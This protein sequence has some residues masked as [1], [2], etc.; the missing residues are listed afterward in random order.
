MRSNIHDMHLANAILGN[1]SP[2][3]SSKTA[4]DMKNGK[5]SA[6]SSRPPHEPNSKVK[7]LQKT[8][9]MRSS[10]HGSKAPHRSQS[11]NFE[12]H[13]DRGGE[14]CEDGILDREREGSRESDMLE[15]LIKLQQSSASRQRQ[16]Q[17]DSPLHAQQD[18]PSGAPTEEANDMIYKAIMH[19][20]KMEQQRVQA[21]M[22]DTRTITEAML[23]KQVEAQSTKLAVAAN[24]Q[25]ATNAKYIE[26]NSG[27]H[28]RIRVFPG[29]LQAALCCMV[30]GVRHGQHPSP[31]N[32]HP[33]KQRRHACSQPG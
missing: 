29:E 21:L 24:T 22:S 14:L 13:E 11:S 26:V 23:R 10:Q 8:S 32:A 27:K 33:Y 19:H 15:D 31:I 2:L 4:S 20:K 17:L 5:N 30:Q 7:P 9:E 28:P 6:H 25:Y 3:Q 18:S 16:M 1:T 12:I